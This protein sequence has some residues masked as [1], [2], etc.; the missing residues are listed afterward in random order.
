MNDRSLALSLLSS[1]LLHGLAIVLAAVFMHHSG[2]VK[3]EFFSVQLLEL[4]A[5]NELPAPSAEKKSLPTVKIAK[6]K[7]ITPVKTDH[8]KVEPPATPSAKKDEIAQTVD[9]K[10]PLPTKAESST[11]PTTSRVEGGGS[12]SGVST[13]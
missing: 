4:P 13:F 6:P 9:A 12:E 7:L 3:A 1:L 2:L 5:Q 10:M 11:I 8:T